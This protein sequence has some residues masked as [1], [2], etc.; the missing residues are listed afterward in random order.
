MTTHSNLN[1]WTP[2]ACVVCGG[3]TYAVISLGDAPAVNQLL[4]L[5]DTS[6]P[7]YPLG[8]VACHNCSHGQQATFVRPDILFSNYP[9][10]SGTSQTLRA[11]F[12]WLAAA[13]RKSRP[14]GKQSLL[15]IGSNDGTF[16]TAAASV[17]FDVIGVDPADA[18]VKKA[19]DS[20]NNVIRGYWPR[21]A[22]VSDSEFDVI[23]AQ[24]VIAHVPDPVEFVTGIVAALKPD[25]IAVIQTSQINMLSSG[26][27]DTIYHEHYSF[28]T[29]ASMRELLR[30]AGLCVYAQIEVDIHGDSMLTIAGKLENFE[31]EEFETA[32][33]YRRII[34]SDRNASSF[35][36]DYA[37]FPGKVRQNISETQNRVKD[38]REKG[39]SVVFVGAAAKA[40][41]YLHVS[42]LVIDVLVDESPFKIGKLEPSGSR[43]IFGLEE[44][45][46]IEK[47]MLAVISAWNFR[48]ELKEKVQIVRGERSTQF[49]TYFPE[50]FVD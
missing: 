39:E 38:A 6:I 17:G 22:E 20:G 32:P 46:R 7:S 1:S 48:S 12:D 10:S 11:Y 37:D 2:V 25:G 18:M 30:S 42:Q 33:Y 15:E 50:H 28:F 40:I 3:D 36:T 16:L 8:L 27:F 19:R 21:V 41:T 45:S 13:L 4:D 26:Q 29:P 31:C 44:L 43:Q 49:L 35:D 5:G 34:D 24:N 9:Y 23:V 14:E 47:P